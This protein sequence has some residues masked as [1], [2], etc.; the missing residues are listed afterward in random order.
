MLSSSVRRVTRV[1][2]P[3]PLRPVERVGTGQSRSVWGGPVHR[4]GGWPRRAQR[5][6]SMTVAECGWG[7]A[8][9]RG[10]GTTTEAVPSSRVCREWPSFQVVTTALDP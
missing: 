1:C 6:S 5:Q 8:R 4:E 7:E 10:P 3:V 9:P 2:S